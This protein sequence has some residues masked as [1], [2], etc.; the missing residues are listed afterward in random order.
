V[1]TPAVTPSK[2]ETSVAPAAALAEETNPGL[3][4]ASPT[5]TVTVNLAVDKPAESKP[6]ED[7]VPAAEEPSE[8]VIEPRPETVP[9]PEEA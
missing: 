4:S 1:S 5:A 3:A 6:A 9:L 8:A 2:N 7:R